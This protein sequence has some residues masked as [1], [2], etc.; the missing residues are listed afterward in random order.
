M[1]QEE[2]KTFEAQF[3]GSVTD[4]GDGGGLTGNVTAF[5]TTLVV[6]SEAASEPPRPLA[7]A[8]FEGR[9]GAVAGAS[10]PGKTKSFNSYLFRSHFSS[11]AAVAASIV[12]PPVLSWLGVGRAM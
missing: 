3:V 7:G 1:A 6:T 11:L 8:E 2:R 12:S 4:G 9:T 5:D 10:D